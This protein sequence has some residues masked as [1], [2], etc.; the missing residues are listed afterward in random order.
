MC[1][2][3]SLLSIGYP[4]PFV[5]LVKTQGAVFLENKKRP[6]QRS[7]T[8][9]ASETLGATFLEKEKN[10]CGNVVRRVGR[11]VPNTCCFICTV[12]KSKNA[13]SI[14]YLR[15]TLHNKMKAIN[16]NWTVGIEHRKSTGGQNP[17]DLTHTTTV[18][19]GSEARCLSE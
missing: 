5:S 16:C 11:P 10:T 7:Q 13:T 6:R 12:R 1:I 17:V 2:H 18:A 3:P 4:D 19:W 14:A 15:S 9:G 8:R